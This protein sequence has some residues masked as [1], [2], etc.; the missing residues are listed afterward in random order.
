MELRRVEPGAPVNKLPSEPVVDD[1]SGMCPDLLQFMTAS[2]WPDGKARALP[3]LMSCYEDGRWRV[4]L[5]D[6]A[7]GRSVWVSGV[8][9]IEALEAI[10]RGLT[11]DCLEWRKNRWTGGRK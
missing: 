1:F 7:N 3:T 6:K 5:N 2:T 11:G 4:C 8:T 9:W 10:D